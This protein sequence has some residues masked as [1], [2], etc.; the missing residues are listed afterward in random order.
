MTALAETA[1]SRAALLVIAV[2]VAGA[3]LRWMAPILNPLLLGMFLAIM[4]DG[5]ARHIQARWPRITEGWAVTLAIGVSALL[6]AGSIYIVAANAGGFI[7]TLQRDEPTLSAMI[8]KAA[9]GLG[10]HAPK[11]IPQIIDQLDPMTYLQS[12]A[13]IVQNFASNAFLVLIYMAFLIAARRGLD[14][15][16]VHIF[17][18]RRARRDA[19]M[20]FKRIRDS[21][22]SYLWIQ[23]VTGVMIAV[24]SWTAMVL[25][26]LDNALFWAFLIFIVN[27]I[28]MVGAA[29]GI[30]LPA[31]FALPQFGQ[32]HQAAL[33]LTIFWLIT[34]VVGNI[35]LPRMQGDSLNM[36]PLVVIIS[37]AFWGALL[38]VTGMF[39]STP[40]TFLVMVILV[41]FEGARWI[42]VLLSANG[43]PD[44]APDPHRR[45]SRRRRS[46]H[47]AGT[48]PE[49]V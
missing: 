30:V 16:A 8:K 14:R 24:A 23:T 33:L 17:K 5:F 1:A 37:L 12:A 38:G 26:G 47:A 13:G 18:T 15:K 31:L 27:Y 4:V 45:R 48:A 34:F 2:V 39:L 20:T 49:P 7:S 44:G 41:Q 19:V 22:E 29:A 28:P 32:W 35:F 42:A 46:T 43:K 9:E 40:L 11:S 3:A 36:D 6:L 25:V 10:P 21:V